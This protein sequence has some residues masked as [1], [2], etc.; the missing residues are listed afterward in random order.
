MEAGSKLLNS[1]LITSM[2]FG[3]SGSGRLEMV[4]WKRKSCS[5]KMGSVEERACVAM[6]VR[7]AKR[8]FPY[9]GISINVQ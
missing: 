2:A 4:C 6:R 5:W 9:E 8:N 3:G 1:A 7:R